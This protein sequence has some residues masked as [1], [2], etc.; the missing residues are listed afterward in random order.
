MT[1]TGCTNISVWKEKIFDLAWPAGFDA[2]WE[3]SHIIE[4]DPN[5]A[6]KFAALQGCLFNLEKTESDYDSYM[7]DLH[8]SQVK[9]GT[10]I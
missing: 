4:E 2:L 3:K 1:T 8:K 6:T 5:A 7:A 10:S 9:T